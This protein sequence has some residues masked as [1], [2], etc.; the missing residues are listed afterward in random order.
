MHKH[1]LAD[2]LFIFLTGIACGVMGAVLIF[3]VTLLYF[4]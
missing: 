4:M 1:L 3:C 2:D